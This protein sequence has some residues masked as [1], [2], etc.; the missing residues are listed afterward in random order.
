MLTA[1]APTTPLPERTRGPLLVSSA[2]FTLG[3]ALVYLSVLPAELQANVGYGVL[4]AAAG[5]LQAAL[6]LGLLTAPSRRR[7]VA[8]AA[9]CLLVTAVWVLARAVGLPGPNP[10]L[11]LDTA[12]GFNDALCVALEVLAAVQL[13]LAAARW[14]R[15]P[16]VHRRWL[17]V[18]AGAPA[19]L[20]AAALTV[21]G[22]AFATNG[23]S[24]VTQAGGPVPASMPAGTATTVTYCTQ[25]GTRLAM[26]VYEP[27][28]GAPRPAPVALYVHGGGFVLGNRKPTG[29]G[30]GLADH[31]GALLPQLRAAL[32]QRGFVVASIDYRL[33]PAS[34]WPA[35]L[36]DVKCA[37]RFLRADAG[38]LGIDPAR[39][40]AW[41][42]SAGGTLVS[43]LG[44]VGPQAG[45]D[46]GQYADQ[47][48]RVQAVVDMFGPA[49]VSDL[50][51]SEA[52]A[53]VLVRI[54]FGGSTAVRR[55]ISPLYRIGSAAG[56]PPFLILHGTA[57]TSVGPRQ[58]RVFA[59]R[60][61][62][63]GIPT[64]L[65]LVQGA[66][67]TLNDPAQHPSPAEVTTLVDDFF[68]RSLPAR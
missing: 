30:A 66:D 25:D 4:F 17:A 18:L 56:V 13:L 11:P 15:P 32:N 58:S 24:T 51:D 39:V 22:V 53:R 63:A 54:G 41:G 23:F 68:A 5:I 6:A 10:W 61:Q 20:L 47:S 33:A 3:G 35:A 27:A 45:Y 12:V 28:A 2:V 59:A 43:L 21:G 14:P 55:S 38:P 65:V 44:L 16:R 8:A 57:D 62:A 42:S 37:V 9:V 48:S 36:R 1:A 7:L 52:P 50:H 31:A 26:D 34:P 40:G 49:D 67:H 60:L 46:T 64:Q 19:V 29:L